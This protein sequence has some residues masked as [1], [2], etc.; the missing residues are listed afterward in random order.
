M[1]CQMT[2][3]ISSGVLDD[4]QNCVWVRNIISMHVP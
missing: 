4:K 3:E 1:R 2:K